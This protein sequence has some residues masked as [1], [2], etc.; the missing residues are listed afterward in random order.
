[1]NHTSKLITAGFFVGLVSIASAQ[2]TNFTGTTG[3]NLED[4]GNWDNG[5]P[6]SGPSGFIDAAG[7]ATAGSNL[8]IS[9]EVDNYVITQN[10]GIV[11]MS[12]GSAAILAGGSWTLNSGELN[13]TGG[14]FNMEAGYVLNLNDGSIVAEQDF[15]VGNNSAS[16][17][18]ATGG[19]INVGFR[20]VFRNGAIVNISGGT[21]T[22]QDEFLVRDSGSVATFSGGTTSIANDLNFASSG[23]L[24]FGVGAV[25]SL[26]ANVLNGG[27][28]VNMDWISGSLMSLTITG[29][30]FAFYEDL[31]I[32][33]NLL[34]DGANAS[35]F[36]DSFQVSG[37]TLSLIPE[38]STFALLAGVLALTS[39]ML[40]RRA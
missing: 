36:A 38:P 7:V 1:M 39:V 25:G 34:L 24:R 17:F 12:G 37:S 6:Q 33:G 13:R 4:S 16:T 9:G 2:I 19:S 10:A 30:D 3:A 5:L 14:D 29:A 23:L 22:F 31:Y 18:N 11:D 28:S 20:A 8:L 27:A 15:F 21:H 32:D 26:T 40:R 35:P